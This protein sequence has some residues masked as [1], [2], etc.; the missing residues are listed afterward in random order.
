MQTKAILF[1]LDGT[2][3]DTAQNFQEIINRF[4]EK[5]H[6]APVDLSAARIATADGLAALVKLSWETSENDPQ[7]G[8]YKQQFLDAYKQ[9]IQEYPVLF[10]PGIEEMLTLIH[11]KIPWGIVTNKRA[12]FTRAIMERHPLFASA[13]TIVSSDT[14]AHSKPHPEPLLYACNEL[15]ISPEYCL[16]IGD[17]HKDIEA[18]TRAGT[19]T[20]IA[21]YGYLSPDDQPNTWGANFIF[22]DPVAIKKWLEKTYIF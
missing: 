17:H 2:L 12:Q 13:K 19:H 18:G 3:L 7:L 8:D 10:F 11:N 16:F 14:T 15:L 9:Y 6:L 5:N 21:L 20:G 4:R 22:N 1:D